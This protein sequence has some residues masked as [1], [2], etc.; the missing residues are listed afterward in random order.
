MN[1]SNYNY[2]TNRN[3]VL[4]W[5]SSKFFKHCIKFLKYIS[6][7]KRNS[8]VIIKDCYW[9]SAPSTHKQVPETY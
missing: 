3:K 9:Y 1:Y 5:V 8:S 6:K 2:E 4:V 7:S